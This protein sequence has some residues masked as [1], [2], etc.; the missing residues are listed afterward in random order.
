MLRKRDVLFVV[1]LAL[2]SI[3]IVGMDDS[4]AG[5]SFGPSSKTVDDVFDPYP[6]RSLPTVSVMFQAA[7]NPFEGGEEEGNVFSD[8][9]NSSLYRLA[10]T[11]SILSSCHQQ[12]N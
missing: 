11:P 2:A 9:E 10:F 8:G 12:E 6:E 3:A 1:T 7:F 5:P 4:I